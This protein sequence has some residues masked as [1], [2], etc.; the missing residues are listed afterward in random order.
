MFIT[1]NTCFEIVKNINSVVPKGI[2]VLF[3]FL[4]TIYSKR[5]IMVLRMRSEEHK[6]RN[7]SVIGALPRTSLHG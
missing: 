2:F 4:Y 7:R 3:I 1:T 5:H 6:C